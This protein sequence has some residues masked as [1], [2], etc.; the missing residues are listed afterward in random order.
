MKKKIPG[1]NIQWPWSQLLLSGKKTIETRT[2]PLPKKYENVELAI[3][4]TPGPDGKKKAGILKARII[5]T[6]VFEN[7]FQYLCEKDWQKDKDKH[8]VK[9]DDKDFSWQKKDSN[10]WGWNVK[11]VTSFKRLI[12][13]PIKRGI[14][15]A[16]KCELSQHS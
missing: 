16:T 5:G 9:L 10:I 4:E 15:F 6:I 8:L 3:I 1:L 2:Y 12:P 7:S 13:A 11:S 14:V